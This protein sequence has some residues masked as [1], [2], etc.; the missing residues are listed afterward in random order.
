M[1]T[2]WDSLQQLI[3][4]LLYLGAGALVSRGWIDEETGAALV[5]AG[6]ALAT[7]IWTYAWNRK[8]VTAAGL[9]AAGADAA[10]RAVERAKAG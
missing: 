3:R 5:G 9:E 1:Q 2:I 6:L 4:I 7:A 8:A 10:A